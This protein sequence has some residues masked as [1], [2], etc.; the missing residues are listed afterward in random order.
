M[1]ELDHTLLADARR[2]SYAANVDRLNAL[3]FCYREAVR[4]QLDGRAF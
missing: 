1:V 3:I 2:V 4:A